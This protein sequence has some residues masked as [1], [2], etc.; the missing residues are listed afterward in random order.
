VK[1]RLDVSCCVRWLQNAAWIVALVCI[2]VSGTTPAR[3]NDQKVVL[4]PTAVAGYTEAE[5]DLAQAALA[6][7]LRMQGLTVIESEQQERSR[8]AGRGCDMTC[9]AR[10]LAAARADL[11]AWAKLNRTDAAL[12]GNVTVTLLDTADH[13]YQGLAEVR[14]GDV[15]DATTRALLEAR[16]YQ[17][18]GP[19]PWLRVIGTPEGAE[20]VLD[21]ERVGTIPYRAA[22][23]PGRHEL[24]VRDIG[25]VRSEQTLQVPA[26]ERRKMEIKIALEPT[27]LEPPLVAATAVPTHRE[28]GAQAQPSE[29]HSEDSSWL[30]APVAVG[31][32][33]LGLAAAISVRLATGL[34]SCV[35]PDLAGT[36]TEKRSVNLA[37][38]IVGYAVSGALLGG[39]ALWIVLGSQK[40]ESAP[41][42][43]ASIGFGR[44]VVTG[45]F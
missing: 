2:V 10:L 12:S 29:Q 14:A 23:R 21:G 45:R 41:H 7:G 36:C 11:S 43:Q 3:A 26:E 25:Y 37:P 40:D 44:A 19:G 16:S 35:N 22:I 1:R 27:P 24:A 5:G 32:L 18:L 20:V 9:G 38:A 15:S 8:T 33:G 17:L 28:P 31:M 34:D 13:P 6:E 39:A 30:A 42:V 4:G